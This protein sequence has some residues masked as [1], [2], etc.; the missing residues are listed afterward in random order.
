MND[1]VFSVLL[2][3]HFMH[4]CKFGNYVEHEVQSLQSCTGTVEL[5][6][7][8]M[9]VVKAFTFV[10]HCGTVPQKK[11]EWTEILGMSHFLDVIVGHFSEL[12]YHISVV[13][14]IIPF[15]KKL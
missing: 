3:A 6:N 12:E 11:V 7:F 5:N 13:E 10:S 8:S 14:I 2:H 9:L 4:Q 1:N 15:L